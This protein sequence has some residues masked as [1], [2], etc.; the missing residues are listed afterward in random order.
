MRKEPNKRNDWATGSRIYLQRAVVVRVYVLLKRKIVNSSLWVRG[1]GSIIIGSTHSRA[2]VLLS[3]LILQS[4]FLMAT[5][6]GEK[7]RSIFTFWGRV[8]DWICAKRPILANIHCSFVL[9]VKLCAHSDDGAF[10]FL[11]QGKCW[12]LSDF[13]WKSSRVTTSFSWTKPIVENKP[14]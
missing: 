12:E 9:M 14:N 3:P 11:G 1:E 4:L 6:T 2:G 13:C 5:L 10:L 7:K 8:R